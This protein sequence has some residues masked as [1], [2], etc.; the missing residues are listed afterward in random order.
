V[1]DSKGSIAMVFA[2]NESYKVVDMQKWSDKTIMAKGLKLPVSLLLLYSLVKD[3]TFS[4]Q[5]Q[6][7]KEKEKVKKTFQ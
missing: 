2:I 4:K 3:P 5:K 7:V 6:K 1:I